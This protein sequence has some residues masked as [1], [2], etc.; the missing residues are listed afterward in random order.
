MTQQYH[1]ESKVTKLDRLIQ[2]IWC[3]L[4]GPDRKHPKH[5]PVT[6]ILRA[7]A[8]YNQENTVIGK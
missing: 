3:G 6:K 5:I 4:L 2:Y 7:N 8:F 1:L